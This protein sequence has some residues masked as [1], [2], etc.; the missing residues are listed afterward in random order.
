[1]LQE[2]AGEIGSILAGID[3]ARDVRVQPIITEPTIEIEVDLDAAQAAG[4]KPGDVRRSATT[5]VSGIQVGALFEE[6]KIFEV[7]VW[8]IPEVRRSVTDVENLLLD[9]P[10]GGHHARRGR[11]RADRILARLD[12]PRCDLPQLGRH[13]CGQRAGPGG[14]RGRPEGRIRRLVPDGVPRRGPRGLHGPD[15][16]SAS[17]CSSPSAP[18][19]ASSCSCARRS[20]AG[21]SRSSA[22]SGCWPRWPAGWW[23]RG[24]TAAPSLAGVAGLLG[25]LAV[26]LRQV[27]MLIGRLQHLDATDGPRTISL[28]SRGRRAGGAGRDDGGRLGAGAAADGLLRVDR[29]PGDREADGG[30]R[31]RGARDHRADGAVRAAAALPAPRRRPASTRWPWPARRASRPLPGSTTASRW[32]PRRS[33]GRFRPSPHP[34]G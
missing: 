13:R 20:R 3:G 34:E 29:R 31:H 23:R 25:V 5:L 6:Q 21:A 22:S 10:G 27:L 18:P 7:Q 19:S 2:K 17:S 11:R 14:G 28:V 33:A 32:A 12:R 26:A 9:V 8:G 30:R 16:R 4:I 24:S 15:R 1:M